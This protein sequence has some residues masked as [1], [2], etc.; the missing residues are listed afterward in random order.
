VEAALI[1]PLLLLIAMGTADYARVFY[2][3]IAVAN[4]ASAGTR[5]AV[6]TNSSSNLTGMQTAATND[7]NVTGMTATA[8]TFCHCEDGTIV[9]CS[10]SCGGQ[11]K[12]LVYVQVRT[13]ATF[14]PLVRHPFIPSSV[15]VNG[16]SVMR[17]Q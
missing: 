9:T 11:G 4:A 5:Y 16:K 13:Q 6:A 3:A 2:V 10:G 17:I 8:S 14:T 15:V 1:F 12:V 7:A